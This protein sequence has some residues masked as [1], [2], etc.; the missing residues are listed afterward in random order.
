MLRNVLAYKAFEVVEEFSDELNVVL[1]CPGCGHLFSPGPSQSDM[2][3][4]YDD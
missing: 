1:K 2:R 3:R 4:M